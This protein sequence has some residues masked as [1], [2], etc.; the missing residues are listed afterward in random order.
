MKINVL[1]KKGDTIVFVLDGATPAF[2]NALRRIM[3]SEIPTLAVEWID[4]H[5]NSSILF[6]EI[7]A[8]RMGMIPLKFDPARFNMPDECKCGGKGCPL[9]QVVFA[10]EKTGPAMVHSGDMKSSDRQVKATS[11]RFPIV[12]LLKGQNLRLDAISRMGTGKNHARWQAANASYQYFP[13][14]DASNC[15]NAKKVISECP[16]DALKL[17]YN[18]VDFSD[19]AR[20]NLCKKCMEVCDGDLVIRGNPNKFI[21]RV[22]TVSGL[23]P[24]HI[25]ESAAEILQKKSEEFKKHVN[26]I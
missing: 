4:F 18:K 15:K 22:E 14:I 7:I 9:C 21:F 8:H 24:A 23:E 26:K 25:V 12:E 1:R 5:D 16:T 2:A 10:V 19:P 11:P 13:E 3:I 17:K 6:D 20:C